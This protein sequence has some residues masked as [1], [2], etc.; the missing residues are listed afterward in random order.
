VTNLFTIIGIGAILFTLDAT[1]ATFILIPIP[2]IVLMIIRYRRKSH[3][4]YHRNWRRSADITSRIN[5]TVPNFLVVR[6]FSKEDYES[7]RLREMLNR[8]YESSVS[9]NKMNSYYWPLMG[10]VVNLSTVIIWWLGGHEVISGVIELGIVTAFI[11]YVS[12][13]YG[14]INNLSNVLPFI[15]QSLTSAERIREVLEVKPQISNSE[16]PK[17]PKMPA[18]IVFD[19]VSFGYDPHFPVIKNVSFMIKPGEKVAIVGK[20]GSGKSTIAKLLLRFYDVDEGKISIGNVDVK[21]ID[22]EYLRK[23]IAYVPQDVVLF[24][25]TVGYNVA[26]GSD[27]V[28]ELDIIR[29]CKIAKIHDEIIKLPFAYDTILGERG[30]YLSGGQRQRLSIARAIIKNPDVLIFDEATSNLDVISEREVYEAMINVSQGKT[31][32]L[33]THNVHEVMNADK[34]IVLDKGKIVEEGTPRDLLSKKSAFYE[35]F[36]D[37]INEENIFTKAK[38]KRNRE[39]QL[40]VVRDL[41]VYPTNRSSRVN[42]QI[43]GIVYHD[44][45]PKMLF[46]ITKP[47]FI[48]FYDENGKEVLLLEDYTKI[49]DENSREVL[50][51]AISYNNLIFKVNK[52][53]EINIK[54]DQLEWNLITDRGGVTTY[55]LGRRNVVVFD[56][57]VVLI[58]KNDNLYEIDLN[59][60]DKKSLNLLLETV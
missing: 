43:D 1:L 47:T 53:N 56:S 50:E 4:L 24:D 10:L 32:I 35:M 54:G 44:L 48:G 28:D 11:A 14:P 19:K 31:V 45:I 58:D 52:I 29:A 2:I 37:Q 60:L 5:D 22:L 3:R 23:K 15:Q 57:K 12:Q 13:F 40:R 21:E 6:S 38:E 41:K 16:S 36:K 49:T 33:I 39:D 25:T 8:L 34:V 27:N 42:V 7:K 46:P 9:I 20:S 17:K 26:Y 18:E 30:T 51:R 55:T 59:Q